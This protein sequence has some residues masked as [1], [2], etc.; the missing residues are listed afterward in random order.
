MGT[1]SEPIDRSVS[2]RRG[3]WRISS[4][5]SEQWY[6]Y[7]LTVPLTVVLLAVVLFPILY[8]L[9]MSV[10]DVNPI[11]GSWDFNGLSN[12]SQALTTLET[13]Q[14]I[15]LTIQYVL[16]M[17]VFSVG[18]ALLGA[19]L[20]NESF[21]GKGFVL[22]LVIL[23]WAVSLYAAAVVWR[24]MY[25]QQF[26]LFNS[27]LTGLGLS[28]QP[29]DFITQTSVLPLI[30][31]AHSW[32]FAPLGIYFMLATLQFIPNDL[33][34]LAK[35]DRLSIWGRFRHVTLPTLKGP[36]LIYLVLVTA[37]AAKAFDITYFISGGGPGTAS[38][39]L[40]F[41]LYRETFVNLNLGYGAAL[42]WIL[43]LLVTGI[44]LVYFWIITRRQTEPLVA[45]EEVPRGE[46]LGRAA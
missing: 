11:I 4:R 16:W 17:T 9:Y 14:S 45:M 38:Q 5:L 8:S 7:L 30:A 39:H 21:K 1:A 41:L 37:E 22:S 44:T 32:Q 27:I 18:I 28:N 33:Y 34:K 42:S 20:L 23:P 15:L 13:W 26:G 6:A 46:D 36:I 2:I 43:V 10:F 35:T 12:Y 19:L 40:V 24:Y 25:S 29:V 31:I 3:R